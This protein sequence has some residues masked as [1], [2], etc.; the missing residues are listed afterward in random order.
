MIQRIGFSA[1]LSVPAT[2]HAGIH[3]GRQKLRSSML[4]SM[5]AIVTLSV[6]SVA[7]EW[8][9]NP[10]DGSPD[11]PYQISTAEQ[12]ISIGSDPDMLDKC[13]ILAN[14]IVFD[15]NND[16]AHVFAEAVIAPDT[17]N[18]NSTYEGIAFTGALNGNG[19][20]VRNLTIDD[21]G[22][23][24]DYLGLFG[25]ITRGTVHNLGI[26]NASVSGGDKSEYLSGLCG[27]NNFGRI[28]NCY[29]EGVVNGYRN[30]GNV[31]GFNFGSVSNCYASGS[32]SGYVDLGGLCGRNSGIIIN[33]YTRGNA[34]GTDTLG[35]LCGHLDSDGV[36]NNCYAITNLEGTGSNIG[37]LVG[38]VGSWVNGQGSINNCYF[39]DTAGTDNGHGTPLTDAELKVESSYLGWDFKNESGNGT[40]EIWTI[41]EGGYAELT[42]LDDSFTEHEFEG[43]GTFTEPYWLY[44][45]AD[46]GAIWQKPYS[47]YRLE[48]DIDLA[49]VSFST[50][51][52]TVFGGTFDGNGY[53]IR[54]L[55]FNGG[56]YLGLFGWLSGEVRNLGIFNGS[57]IS[58]D[59][60]HFLGSL[61][62]RNDYGRIIN[63]YSNASVMGGTTVGGLAGQNYGGSLLNCYATGS[64]AGQWDSGGLLGSN[65]GIVSN[66]NSTGTVAGKDNVGG[67]VGTNYD[68]L[69]NCYSS[70]SVN[71]S[72]RIGGLVGQNR[73]GLI[74]G[75]Y[76]TALVGGNED[77]G[78]LIG[79]DYGA[80]SNCFAAG[81]VTGGKE[82]GGF[83]GFSFSSI[84]NCYS[85]GRVTGNSGVGG[86]M[87]GGSYLCDVINCFWDVEKSGQTRG[88]LATG[89]TTTEMHEADIFINVGWDFINESD[90]GMGETWHIPDD[91]GCPE[92]SFFSKDAPIMLEGA[93]TK[94]EPYLIGTAEE[95]C[96][97]KW[98]PTGSFFKQIANI[99]LS[100]MC[101][102]EA[103]VG[104]F[105]GMFEGNG[106]TISNLEINGGG[107][108]GLFGYLGNRSQINDA[109]LE[110]VT[111]TSPGNSVAGLAGYSEGDLFDCSAKVSITGGLYIDFLG[112]LVGYNN[113]GTVSMCFAD[114]SVTGGKGAYHSG[115][116]MGRNHYGEVSNCYATGSVAGGEGVG[117]LIGYNWGGTVKDCFATNTV[118]GAGSS[119]YLGG[120]AGRNYNGTIQKCF[121]TGSVTGEDHVG[122]LVGNNGGGIVTDCYATGSVQGIG[123]SYCAGGLVGENNGFVST[124]YSTGTVTGRYYVNGL[125]G[126]GPSV[127]NSFWD[128]ETSGIGS[129]GSS[130]YGAV[131]KTT[132]EL[133]DIE[134]FLVAG[135]DFVGESANGTKEI[136]DIDEGTAYPS[137]WWE[138]ISNTEPTAQAGED[139]DVYAGAG[140]VAEV[141]LDG[142]GSSDPDG[143]ELGYLW[144]WVVEGQVRTA[145]GDKPVIEL[146]RGEYVITLV[147]D[148]GSEDSL[149]DELV[150]KV[151]NVVPV[152]DAGQDIT[153]HAWIDGVAEVALDGSGSS[154]D[155]GDELSY[156]WLL[157][158]DEIAVGVRPLVE[159]P[160][161]EHLI[162]LVVWDGWDEASDAVVVE[163]VGP[164]EASVRVVP[165]VINRKSRGRSVLAVMQLPEGMESSDI[166]QGYGVVFE[167]GGVE[168]RLWRVL[169]D[170]GERSLFA[171]FDRDKVIDAMGGEGDAEVN[172]VCRLVSGRYLYGAD[173]IKVIDNGKGPK[174]QVRGRRERKKE[175]PAGKAR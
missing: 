141:A 152:A 68:A 78:G 109:H 70:G 55:N 1:T 100:G 155:N 93:G 43:E 64:V 124:C 15:P 57:V 164:M 173:K 156:R 75:C 76:S 131:G 142:S 29:V 39:L 143:D 168:A 91:G 144:S 34:K 50:S 119:K 159:L 123:S 122:G 67:L 146:P 28:S 30:I 51:V 74:L 3:R 158:G 175:A 145:A 129:S 71:G 33:C 9:T 105:N 170:E 136:W 56:S 27:Y 44:D 49:G 95:L 36:I 63:C 23:N 62:G 79:I 53:V 112:G 48:N 66:C 89:L 139:V 149:P 151:L 2:V 98:F 46:L 83:V 150:A 90:N 42:V 82:V 172:V 165:R 113:R 162:E 161:G 140:G 102:S 127:N 132:A 138:V 115:G 133:Y 101:F 12:L 26:E 128:V 72:E 174:R 166:D 114:G 54:N 117:G 92:L 153:T 24:N 88:I 45:A 37:S 32:I 14:D 118:S 58:G 84:M 104:V 103:V 125:V 59:D 87:G 41:P 97:V 69:S 10:G 130:N 111:I 116:L 7:Y 85:T 99:D 107:F 134:T 94:A 22:V 8:G 5:A 19:Y 21:G 171:M 135:W 81:D 17:D 157:D 20:V 16:P 13:F 154:D 169:V 80:T 47:H 108:L 31:C 163:V 160:V 25:Y 52:A 73:Y 137:L 38:Y 4:F 148:D 96:M 126:T 65:Y 147:V 77:V 35:G 60:S 120:L 11:D 61:C 6:S 18:T 40:G 121:A 167:P 110:N 106:H 86:F